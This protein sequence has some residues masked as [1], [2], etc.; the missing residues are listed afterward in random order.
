MNDYLLEKVRDYYSGVMSHEERIRFEAERK[1]NKELDAICELFETIE[2]GIEPA[3]TYPEQE[4]A[5]RTT[6]KKF[7]AQY[8][9][10]EHQQNPIDPR[11]SFGRSDPDRAFVRETIPV[12]N[13]KGERTRRIHGWKRLA[14]AAILIGLVVWG[15]IWYA[16]NEKSSSEVTS[17]ETGKRVR[18]EN[19][20]V[21]PY[22]EDSGGKTVSAP[23]NQKATDS[24]SNLNQETLARDKADH[25]AL[26]TRNFQPYE[27]P[28]Q[29]H[30][31]LQAA[32]EHY[33]NQEYNEAIAAI[34]INALTSSL[35]ELRPRGEQTTAAEAEEK[36]TIFYAHYYKGLSYMTDGQGEK[37]I[38]QLQDAVKQSPDN[39][40]KSKAQWYLALAYLKA[41]RI[42]QAKKLL[43]QVA[44]SKDAGLYRKK[45]QELAR[46]LQST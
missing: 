27:V 38:A 6:L 35:E 25:E 13:E 15:A 34:D 20:D 22:Q 12:H 46:N 17:R 9:S 3:E 8:H 40:W 1:T 7:Q 41:G 24:G 16:Q 2:A 32:L 45:A 28:T 11:Y 29:Y 33:K 36:Q 19:R 10:G 5:L 42:E 23:D 18:L 21:H 4:A 26:F 30:D 39:D 43:H 14:A 31:L 37:A 44:N